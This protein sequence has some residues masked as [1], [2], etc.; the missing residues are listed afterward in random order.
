MG[1]IHAQISILALICAAFPLSALAQSRME[2]VTPGGVMPAASTNAMDPADRLAM[3]LRLLSQ[4]P[5]DVTALTQA[6]ES[7]LAVGDANAAISFLARAEELSPASGRIK[8]DLASALVQLER[9]TEAMRLFGEAQGLG[10]SEQ[11]FAKDRGLAFDLRGENKRAQRD[12]ALALRNGSDEEV[13]RRMAMSL[14]ISG[15]KDEALRLL[16][17]LIRRRDQGAWRA[18]AFILA[19]NGDLRGAEKIADQVVPPAMTSSFSTFMRRLA[20]LSPAERAHAVNFGSMPSQDVRYA[21]V[22]TN[23]PFRPIDAGASDALS[24]PAPLI[25]AAPETSRTKSSRDTRRRPGRDEIALASNTPAFLS[26]PR[27]DPPAAAPFPAT[28]PATTTATVKSTFGDA[29]L[30]RR[31]GERLGPVDPARLPDL[32]RPTAPNTVASPPPK[33]TLMS[34]MTSLPVPTGVRPLESASRSPSTP[35]SSAPLATTP[36]PVPTAQAPALFEIATVAPK[37]VLFPPAPVAAPPAAIFAPKPTPVLSAAAPN[38]SLQPPSTPARS[39]P[40]LASQAPAIVL[41]PAAPPVFVAQPA[42][43]LTTAAPAITGL[44][45]PIAAPQTPVL[46]AAPVAPIPTALPVPLTSAAA[47]PA[48]GFSPEIVAPIPVADPANSV[49]TPLPAAPAI[50]EP[51]SPSLATPL[52]QAGVAPDATPPSPELIAT[53][54]PAAAP[55]PPITAPIT[56]LQVQPLPTPTGLASVLSGITPEEE[57]RGGP[58]LSDAEFRKARLIA[59]RKAEAQSAADSQAKVALETKRQEEEERRRVAALSPQRFWVQIAT[60]ANRSGLS[61]TV[62]KLRDQAPDALKGLSAASVPYKATNRVLVGPFKTQAEARNIVNKL[63]KQGVSATTF[64]SDA[65]QDVAKL[66]SR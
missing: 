12:Y 34:G 18:R 50:L 3:N 1:R 14:G 19:M 58:V 42:V 32:M 43:A 54:A 49:V 30:S 47:V 46:V 6:G 15:N 20:N 62:K 11:S 40:T 56:P 51:A 25:A 13:I 5:Y 28:V 10:V 8:A 64:T 21:A 52:V 61:N 37:P 2:V 35:L 9:P 36:A 55:A 45:P 63:S 59:R 57:S 66:S 41:A 17:P 65:G 38:P 39:T 4:N 53:P 29:P 33:V 26:K 31:V 48:P 22:N 23:D 24:P 7:A 16:D 27:V 60:G 44:A